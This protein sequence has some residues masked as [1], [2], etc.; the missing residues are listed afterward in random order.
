MIITHKVGE[1]MLAQ[2]KK[3]IDIDAP[4]PQHD[5]IGSTHYIFV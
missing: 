5:N 1:V 4:F 2:K 3:K